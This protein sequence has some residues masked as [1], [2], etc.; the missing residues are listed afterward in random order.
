MTKQLVCTVDSWNYGSASYSF[1]F[2][3]WLICQNG[4]AKSITFLPQ[5]SY[6][7]K[8]SDT[9]RTL[10]NYQDNGFFH[11]QDQ[12]ESEETSAI[13]ACGSEESVV[14]LINN[15]NS[16][17]DQKAI[18]LFAWAQYGSTL[19]SQC[20]AMKPATWQK[21]VLNLWSN[22]NVKES[23]LHLDNWIVFEMC[24]KCLRKKTVLV[25]KFYYFILCSFTLTNQT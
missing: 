10:F 3:V 4:T 6:D 12:S 17:I 11:I 18:S 1:K 5:L 16:C 13:S 2:S 23:N 8:I 24:S 9:F 21:F 20:Y 14:D 22:L 7:A 25:G 19:H 15:Y